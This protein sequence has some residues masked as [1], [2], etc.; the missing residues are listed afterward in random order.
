MVNRSRASSHQSGYATLLALFMLVMLSA[1]MAILASG[2]SRHERAVRTTDRNLRLTAL[3]D[4]GV[5]EALSGI[6]I[7]PSYRGGGPTALGGGT[8]QVA[9]QVVGYRRLEAKVE[10]EYG[11]VRRTVVVE[12]VLEGSKARPR[13]VSWRRLTTSERR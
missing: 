11:D 7:T 6:A 10:A 1:G 12:V 4:A 8:Y 9:A 3:S 5:A 13:V 2:V